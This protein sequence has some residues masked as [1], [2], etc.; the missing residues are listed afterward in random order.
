VATALL[1]C[2]VA[3]ILY[4]QEKFLSLFQT[5]RLGGAT[6]FSK[7]DVMVRGE[8]G[9]AIFFS[10]KSSKD[11]RM[12]DGLTEH[13]GCPV[14]EGEKW[15]VTASFREGVNSQRKL[16]GSD[17]FSTISSQVPG[18]IRSFVENDEL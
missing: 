1:H 2:Q 17:E 15:I 8:P 12:D 6:S 5:A 3:N 11:N 7:V 14:L 16:S 18:S 4:F 10:Y 9:L 13:S